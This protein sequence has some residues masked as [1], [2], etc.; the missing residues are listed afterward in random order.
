MKRK[1]PFIIPLFLPHAACPHHC[2]FCNQKTLHPEN[3]AVDLAALRRERDRWLAFPRDGER[4]VEL[5][6]FGGNFLGL[7]EEDILGCVALVSETEG[8]G[9]RVST[10]PDSL[11]DRV[12]SLLATGGAGI[13]VEL[14]VQS[15]DD[16]VLRRSAR[17]HDAASVERAVHMLRHYPV[18]VGAQMMLGLPGATEAS[19]RVS[20]QKLAALGVDFVRVAP[21]LVLSGSGLETLYRRGRYL[22]LDFAGAVQRTAVFSHILESC[23]IPVVR[24][25]LQEDD[26]LRSGLVAGPHHP[27]FG[28][29][30]RGYLLGEQ[31]LTALN[32]LGAPEPGEGIVIRV[33]P[34]LRGRLQGMEGSNLPR[35]FQALFPAPFR[36]HTE[37]N[38]AADFWAVERE[39]L[40]KTL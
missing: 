1:K 3:P 29:W 15:L 27:A 7:P 4:P 18:R 11:Q 22:P 40:K 28:E 12:L 19:D 33:S 13:T 5:A 21:T 35:F 37:R 30:V 31:V 38:R 23:G 39:F 17:G 2:L 10:R 32:A 24:M 14:G 34:R 9:I 26:A 20:A 25:G 6:F 36:I 8:A 16:R